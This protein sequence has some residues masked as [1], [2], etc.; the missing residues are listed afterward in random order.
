MA[1]LELPSNVTS[2]GALFAARAPLEDTYRAIVHDEVTGFLEDVRT[3][4]EEAAASPV[5]QMSLAI[6]LLMWSRRVDRVA[7]LVPDAT[8]LLAGLR[9]S[10]LPNAAFTAASSQAVES[11]TQQ[12]PRAQILAR[13]N[14]SLGLARDPVEGMGGEYGRLIEDAAGGPARSWEGDSDAMARTAST[15]DFGSAM[16][17]QLRA[18]GYTH[19][20]WMT[21]FDSRV[22]E[23]HGS[24][25]RV[26]I[27]LG[28]N[29]TVG[30]ASL[31]F[32]ADPLSADLSEV[33][34]C[35]CVLA[36]VRFGKRELDHEPGT[37]PWNNPRP[38]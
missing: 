27:P 37:E 9:E 6:V 35:R 23:T 25:D 32:P 24:A 4:V 22:R 3:Y 7:A 10:T 31:R 20:R 16:L 29:F 18:D 21:R 33:I 12:L 1:E 28:E 38:V 19:K 5:P 11:L 8:Q 15:A 30:A 36:G 14:T 13:I 2:G 26:T 17:D 34:N